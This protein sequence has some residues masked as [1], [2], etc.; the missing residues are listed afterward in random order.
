MGQFRNTCLEALLVIQHGAKYFDAILQMEFYWI[1]TH[2][3]LA[4]ETYGLKA[5]KIHEHLFQ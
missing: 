3:I 1:H 4:C 2:N 5:C